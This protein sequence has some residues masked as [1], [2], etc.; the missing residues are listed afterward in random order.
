[1]CRD[2]GDEYV[3]KRQLPLAVIKDINT[4]TQLDR[5]IIGYPEEAT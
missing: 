4:C 2:T 1:M 3:T 5:N